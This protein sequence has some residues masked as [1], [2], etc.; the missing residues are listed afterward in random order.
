MNNGRWVMGNN[1]NVWIWCLFFFSVVTSHL[2]WTANADAQMTSLRFEHLTIADGLPS[3][4]ISGIAQDGDGLMWFATGNG[5]AKYDGYKV[6]VYRHRADDSTTVADSYARAIFADRNGGIWVGTNNGLCY[7]DKDA[8]R[9]K[10]YLTGCNVR[11]IY[12][13]RSGHLWLGTF[14]GLIEF[15]PDTQTIRTTYQNK[16]DDP[17]SLSDNRV[18]AVLED[19]LGYIWA[20][21]DG[22]GLNRLDRVSGQF[23]VFRHNDSDSHSL[24]YDVV[25]SLFEDSKQRLW[26]GTRSGLNRFDRATQSFKV[27]QWPAF[28]M[29]TDVI[30]GICE[31]SDRRLWICTHEGLNRFNPEQETAIIY[32]QTRGDTRSL[33][34]NI[35]RTLYLS[36]RDGILW[37]GTNDGGVNIFHKATEQFSLYSI[38]PDDST[39]LSDNIIN[40]IVEDRDRDLWVATF[41]GGLNQQ[42]P[43]GAGFIHHT[44]DEKNSGSLSYN[45]LS[46]TCEDA[47]GNM[48]IGTYGGGLDLLPAEMK[49]R[50]NPI[51]THYQNQPDNPNSLGSNFIT[52]LSYNPAGYLWIGTTT[53][54][55]NRLDL[56]AGPVF[57]RFTNKPNDPRSLSANYINTFYE[58]NTGRLWIGTIKG[59]NRLDHADS[60]VFTRFLHDSKNPRSLSDNYVN[61][62]F[63]DS[64]G[65]IWI[66]TGSGLNKFDEA[67]GGFKVYHETDG[68]TGDSISGI[69]E[70]D[71]GYL[72]ISTRSGLSRFDS[73]TETFTNYDEQD[74]L[75][76]N[77]FN[78]RSIF[79]AKNGRIYLGGIFGMTAFYP[80]SL[81]ANTQI[82]AVRITGFRLFNRPAPIA[83]PGAIKSD[84]FQL[85]R[86]ISFTDELTLAYTD[87]IFSFEFTAL[88]YYQRHKN[89]FAYQLTGFDK[90]WISTN[91]GERRATYT[92]IPHGTYIFR[93][94]A[95]NNNGVWNETGAAIKIIIT[96]P[97]WKTWWAYALYM[98]MVAVV[99]VGFVRYQQL[100]VERKHKELEREREIS[101]QLRQIDKLKDDF[102][103]NTSHELRTP[104]NGIIGIAESLL[105][106]AGGAPSDIARQNLNMIILS[107]RRLTNLVNDILDFSKLHDHELALQLSPIDMRALT[108]VVFMQ[109]KPLVDVKKLELRNEIPLDTPLVSGDENRLQQIMLNLLGNAVKFTGQGQVTVNCQLLSA[110]SQLTITVSDTGIG[111][112]ADKFQRIF[113]SFAQADGSTAREYGGTG[114]GLAVTKRLVELHG[115]RIWVES[116]PGKGS[117]FYFTLP[118]AGAG[119]QP[120]VVSS[121]R[122]VGSSQFAIPTLPSA[123]PQSAIRTLQSTESRPLKADSV[124]ILVVDD[125]PVNVQ[126]LTNH[127]SLNHYQVLQAFNG[128]E[129]LEILEQE[130]VQLVLL[131]VM[132][133]RMSGYEVCHRIRAKQALNQLPVIMLTAKTQ[134]V[135]I[136]SGFEA[137]ANDYVTKPFSRQEILARVQTH[138]QL[139]ES[140]R[141]L[142]QTVAERTVELHRQLQEVHERT[143]QIDRQ[144]RIL[145]ANKLDLEYK[146]AALDH[147]L[148]RLKETQSQL[149]HTEKMSALGHLVAGI[150]HEVNSPLGA[151]H[152]SNSNIRAALAETLRLLPQILSRL[153]PEQLAD[154]SALLER[155]LE[156]R[157]MLT[158]REERQ[159]RRALQKTL[160]DLGLTNPDRI[161]DT[162]VDMGVLGEI[163]PFV[164]LLKSDTDGQ[165]LQA[166][167]NVVSQQKSSLN[168]TTAIDRASKVIF[169]LKTYAH[170][171]AG[172][173]MQLARITDTIETVLTLYYNKLRQGVEVSKVYEDVPPILCHPDQLNQVWT[174]LIHNAIQAM[175]NKGT[176]DIKVYPEHRNPDD[177][178]NKI[179]SYVVVTI[180]D[181]GPGIPEQ[182]KP[183]VFEPFFTTK[184]AGEG[185]GLGLEIVRRIVVEGHKGTIDFD[186]VP[187]RTTFRVQLPV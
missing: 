86:H 140:S 166:A 116:S 153:T 176:L 69:T 138:L 144:N 21:T 97:W 58:D 78:P 106:G 143:V 96:P 44:H 154:F 20:A 129:A 150:A 64:R 141:H 95:T 139:A 34:S 76:A 80:D 52:H 130:A 156:N 168:I 11:H 183:R 93:V 185:S 173:Q 81:R 104:L 40:A 49:N 145:T 142:E 131:D 149:I 169:A 10:R 137:G 4:H 70:D 65:A 184:S 5:V 87:Y 60:A 62:I 187:G 110:T 165:I 84:N 12:Q 24:S 43:G 50:P 175:N 107:G 133:P 83:K 39:S 174:N 120:S 151:I 160:E 38:I 14:N 117:R 148:N 31:D 75:Q 158:S 35:I 100:K 134:I 55:L 3:N 53:S 29:R 1:G 179:L 42:R 123:D 22:S 99:I 89:Q 36:K 66:G 88:N 164:R 157:T 167:Y 124:T 71:H 90:D 105:D 98:G 122:S 67:T 101:E 6:T 180:T 33:N 92:N 152:A 54:G 32:R 159:Y 74:G 63:Q 61:F 41:G 119:R 146:N 18:I 115:G 15:D 85:S 7:F 13:D 23:Q 82:P 177:S 125:E 51:F 186:S 68:L 48:W 46:S 77:E 155:G 178:M 127:L 102:M 182:V 8:E 128:P 108:E 113:E 112:S 121:P 172:G 30:F 72:W 118:L 163:E 126:V 47:A 26:V 136:V 103:A 94:K 111:I 16:S 28:P 17:H 171:D 25:L 181:N 57:K 19:H 91:A 59:L 162:L 9:F 109:I 37:I 79:K 45:I 114:L 56:T 170:H 135:D 147:A 73:Q 132:M 27:Y 2:L 161:A